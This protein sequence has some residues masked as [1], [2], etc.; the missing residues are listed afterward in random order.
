MKKRQSGS[1]AEVPSHE[2]NYPDRVSTL[3]PRN[4]YVACSLKMEWQKMVR[5][6]HAA[7]LAELKR[8]FAEFV[9]VVQM[10][11]AGVT[12]KELWSYLTKFDN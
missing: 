7:E 8:N 2:L 12:F 9:A 5:P 11:H 4:Q 6:I 10:I 3:D 1:R